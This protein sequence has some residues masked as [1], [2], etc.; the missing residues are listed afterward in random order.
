MITQSKNTRYGYIRRVMALPLLFI[1]FCAFGL[2]INKH[3][4]ASP[5]FSNKPITIVVDAG[6]GGMFEG[7]TSTKGVLEKDLNLSIAKKIQQLSKEYNVNVIMTR[8][9]DATV[10]NAKSLKEDLLNRVNVAE[11]NKADLFISVHVDASNTDKSE[12]GFSVYVS[13]KNLY[14]QKSIAL[15]SALTEEIKNTYPIAPELKERQEGIIVLKVP[16]MPAVLIECGYISNKNDL[17][18]ITDPK[19]Q[20]KIAR[21][22]LEGVEKYY[23]FL[24]K[25]TSGLNKDTISIEELKKI[26]PD[27]IS[28]MNVWKEKNI[29]VVNLK[30]GDS[31]IAKADE[32]QKYMTENKIQSEADSNIIFT[33]VE[34]EAE[35]PGGQNGWKQYL[36]KN[37][38][39]PADAI[40]RNI[41]GTVLMQFIVETD[42]SLSDIKVLERPDPS[43]SEVSYKIIQNS[44]KWIPATEHGQK[45]RCY[46]KQ[47]I[48]FKLDSK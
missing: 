28:R 31:V 1:L 34:V 26:N 3:K 19:N 16:K 38:K 35:Y 12:N 7:A 22:I 2:K 21:N 8:D 13:N 20:E 5:F 9:N 17:A 46:K 23:A 25:P 18:F 47:P 36:V 39:Y 29:I 10:G 11:S 32:F 27:D 45:V 4:K 24:N 44:G 41:Q 37:L 48:I 14:Y 43:L 33:K 42:G 40:K 15:A 6:H 30:N